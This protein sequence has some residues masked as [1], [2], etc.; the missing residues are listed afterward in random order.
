M[1]VE[2]AERR[3]ILVASNRGP[4]SFSRDEDGQLTAKRGGGGVVSGLS[5]VA[6]SEDMLWVCAALS[7]AD[8]AAARRGTRRPAR[9]RRA[10]GRIGGADARHPAGHLQPGLQHRGQLGALVRAPHALRHAEPAPVR[11]S[12]SHATGPPTA[13]TTWR[14][15]R[16][17]PPTPD[18]AQTRAVIQDYHLT[19]APRML[20]E[21]APGVK[22]AHF[23][24]T[25]WA[26]V[27]YYRLLPDAVGA[28]VL[29][30]HTRRRSRGLPVPALGRRVHGLLRADPRCRRST[31]DRQQVSYEGHVTGIGIHPLGVDAAGADRPRLPARCRAR[32]GQPRRDDR[33]PEADR[34][35]RPH[36]ALEEHR[37]GPGRLP[38]AAARPGRNGAARS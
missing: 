22:I 37:P 18:Q 33:R 2:G 29:D 19:L 27:D 10:R 14:S 17:W 24:H 36:R 32:D 23:S 31:A 13:S 16:R 12:P 38:R 28:E 3:R 4:V 11:A 35:G 21:L 26:P 20:A 30:G 8:R 5:S 9:P 6:S 15:R 7:E 1:P 34:A 25:P